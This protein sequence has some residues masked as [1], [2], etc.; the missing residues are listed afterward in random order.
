MARRSPKL[1]QFYLSMLIGHFLGSLVAGGFGI[2]A[3]FGTDNLQKLCENIED[4]LK[5]HKT[6][7]DCTSI[8]KSSRAWIIVL[9]V[10]SWFIEFWSVFIVYSYRRELLEKQEGRK[11]VYVEVQPMIPEGNKHQSYPAVAP[12]QPA[13]Y[14]PY[15]NNQYPF[16]GHGANA[17]T[18]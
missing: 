14:D 2:W 17:Y 18:K 6:A 13:P 1:L 16:E 3:L 15:N 5:D 9:I 7:E 4:D 10:L 12:Y 8:L 11:G